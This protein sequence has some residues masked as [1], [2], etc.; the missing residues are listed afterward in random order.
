[1]NL[2]PEKKTGSEAGWPELPKHHWAVVGKRKPGASVLLRLRP[3]PTAKNKEDAESGIL[4][5]QNYGFGRVLFLGL[6]SS[7]RWRYRVGDLYHHRF[8]GQLVRWAAADRLLPAGNRFIRYGPTE[9]IYGPGEEVELAVRLGEDLPPLSDPGQ[10]RAKVYRR[11][12]D[13]SEE[14]AVESPLL[15]SPRQPLRLEAKLLRLPPGTYRMEVDI[16]Q[17]REQLAQP[18]EGPAAPGRNLFRVFPSE[19][20]ELLNLST[21]PSLLQGLANSSDGKL[22]TP[23]DVS[24]LPDRLARRVERITHRQDSKPWQDEPMVWWMLGLLLGLLTLEWGWR[25]WL[26]LA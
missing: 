22:Y 1:L 11:G 26:D 3:E 25:K 16:P 13:G 19:Q 2:E 21:N 17:Y 15:A 9:P 6:D 10:A 24:Q 4:L 5:Q 23:E 14:L 20:A 8:W 18:P 7:W 12:A